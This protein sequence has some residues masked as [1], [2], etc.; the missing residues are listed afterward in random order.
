M[1]CH[2][3]TVQEP[4]CPKPRLELGAAAPGLSPSTSAAADVLAKTGCS[5]AAP[6]W[7]YKKKCSPSQIK[8]S[9]VDS[10]KQTFHPC[11]RCIGVTKLPLNSTARER[12][13]T[14]LEAR[15]HGN[16]SSRNGCLGRDAKP[17]KQKSQSPF[18]AD[19]LGRTHIRGSLSRP[20]APQRLPSG[21]RG[22]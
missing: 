2:T 14:I 18:P 15:R 5:R 1:H 11:C 22:S 10:L 8:A 21:R 7:S 9:R 6:Q 17:F 16:R 3:I 19:T 12:Q 13:Q 20:T 4:E